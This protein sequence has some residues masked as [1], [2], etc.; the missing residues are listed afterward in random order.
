MEYKVDQW[1]KDRNYGVSNGEKGLSVTD[2]SGTVRTLDT[3][4]LTQK[5]DGMYGTRQSISAAL[6]NSNVGAPKGFAPLR[7]TLTASGATVG[8]APQSDAPI[9]NGQTLNPNDSRIVKVGDDYWIDKGYADSFTERSYQN[10]YKDEMKS[11]LRSLVRD[12]FS[13]DPSKDT[14]LA[15]AQE[16][17]M[18]AAKQSANARGLL[19]GS[20]AEIM[21]QNAAAQLIPQ[22][23]AM[24][25]ARYQDEKDRKV[26]TLSVLDSLA[27]NAFAEYNEG[28]AMEMANKQYAQNVQ[29]AQEAS[30]DHAFQQQL[31]RVTTIGEVDEEAA[32]VLHLPVGTLTADRREF[33]EQ[34]NQALAMQAA[35]KEQ[36]KELQ[37]MKNEAQREQEE[38]KFYHE[39]TLAAMEQANELEKLR[40]QADEVIRRIR[41]VG[42]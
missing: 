22:Y 10:P 38:Q 30:A 23:E 12:N 15:A 24:A 39:Q 28:N 8:Y 3:T 32:A 36:A 41:A 26:K 4:G 37:T 9:V 34:F 40:A 25:Y 16:N 2:G 20:T 42:K 27:K 19:G 29:E 33:L 21:R 31:K 6:S 35:E 7:N 14:A 1:L 5:A 11:I 17:A 18:L 13:Y